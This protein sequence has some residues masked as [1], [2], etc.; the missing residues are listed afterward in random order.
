MSNPDTATLIMLPLVPQEYTG[1]CILTH[2]WSKYFPTHSN[3]NVRCEG[4]G[5]KGERW[6]EGCEVRGEG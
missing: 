3:Y 5:V 6:G 2:V 4:G 1:K